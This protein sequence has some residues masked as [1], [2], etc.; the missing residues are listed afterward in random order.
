M[1]QALALLR[2]F[3]EDAMRVRMKETRK[4]SPD[5]LTISEYV[6]GRVY[7]IPFDLASVFVREG[8]G[9]VVDVEPVEQP[10]LKAKAMKPR[11]PA[12]TPAPK[13][14]HLKSNRSG[15]TVVLGSKRKA[16]KLKVKR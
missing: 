5:G 6:A 3:V 1:L 15:S 16:P 2:V 7:E 11:A 10:A 12:E 14:M 4:G 8:W 13:P 9:V